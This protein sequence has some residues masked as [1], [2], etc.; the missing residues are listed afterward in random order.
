MASRFPLSAL[1]SIRLP[2]GSN[3][4]HRPLTPI[5]FAQGAALRMLGQHQIVYNKLNVCSDYAF[6]F[7]FHFFGGVTDG[8]NVLL[9]SGCNGVE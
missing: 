5:A 1:T 8:T 9:N 7:I 6:D 3:S 2:H 4:V